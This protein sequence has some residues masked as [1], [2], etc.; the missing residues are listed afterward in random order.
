MGANFCID[1]GSITGIH[2]KRCQSCANRTHCFKEGNTYGFVKGG[3]AWNKGKE[4]KEK[5]KE[6]QRNAKD[7]HH[8]W[9]ITNEG[10]PTD[11]GLMWVTKGHHSEIHAVLR[12][13][14]WT[15]NRRYLAG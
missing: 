6:K 11:K 3:I 14:C 2:A 5:T 12:H 1:C 7:R 9:Y 13:N 10:E 8:I 4:T 15:D